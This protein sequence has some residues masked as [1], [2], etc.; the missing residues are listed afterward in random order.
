MILSFWNQATEDIY[1]GSDSKGARSVP[2]H[3]WKIAV[4]KLDMINAARVIGD[5]KASPGNRLE[6]MKG[7]WKGHHSIRVNDEYRI[8]FVWTDGNAKD[9]GIVDYHSMRVI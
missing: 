8:V 4:R 9:S 2:Q 6:A 1:H 5:L 3:L 7:K